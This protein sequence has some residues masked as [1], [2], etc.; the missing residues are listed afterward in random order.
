VFRLVFY[1]LGMI[2]ID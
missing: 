2:R 1:E